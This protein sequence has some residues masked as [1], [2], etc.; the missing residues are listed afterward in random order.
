MSYQTVVDGPFCRSINLVLKKWSVEFLDN[1]VRVPE[2][3]SIYATRWNIHVDIQYGL[4]KKQV[5]KETNKTS[6]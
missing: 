1:Q 2:C 4:N 6:S 5:V 3:L